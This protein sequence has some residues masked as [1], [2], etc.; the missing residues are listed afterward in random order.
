[1]RGIR[2]S[3]PESHAGPAVAVKVSESGSH[4][5]EEG[6]EKTDM[7]NECELPINSVT[8][9]RLKWLISLDQNGMWVVMVLSSH[10]NNRPYSHRRI[11]RP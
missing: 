4:K 11:G 8:F 10:R 3:L 6:E 2:Q 1:V 7:G 5:L 9:K